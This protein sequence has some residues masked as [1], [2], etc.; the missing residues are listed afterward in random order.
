[1]APIINPWWFYLFNL[2]SNLRDFSFMYI[3]IG[4]III[5]AI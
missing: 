2:I 5:G 3:G 4:G 1:M